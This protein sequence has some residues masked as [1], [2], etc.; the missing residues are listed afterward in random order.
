MALTTYYAYQSSMA[1][2]M[3]ALIISAALV[4]G[5]LLV[6]RKSGGDMHFYGHLSVWVLAAMSLILL[7]QKIWT[8]HF[9][10]LFFTVMFMFAWVIRWY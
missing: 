6:V 5:A 7:Q 10:P 8:N 4:G 1:E 3:P 2:L 9:Y